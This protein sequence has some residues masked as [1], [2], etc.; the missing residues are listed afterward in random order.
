MEKG[1]GVEETRSCKDRSHSLVKENTKILKARIL[2]S[3]Q[4]LRASFLLHI[5]DLQ[6]F[7]FQDLVCVCGLIN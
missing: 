3:S 1:S 2:S 4:Y 7:N 6:C 5:I